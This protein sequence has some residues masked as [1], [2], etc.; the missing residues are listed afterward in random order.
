MT[1]RG[2]YSGGGGG[3]P[4]AGFPG[5]SGSMAPPRSVAGTPRHPG[6]MTPRGSLTPRPPGSLTPGGRPPPASPGQVRPQVFLEYSVAD[7]AST[8]ISLPDPDLYFIRSNV[9][10]IT[11]NI[12]TLFFMKKTAWI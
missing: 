10:K 9:E 6:S 1:P 2:G 5:A 7:S 8:L 12:D 4:R 11:K 3:T